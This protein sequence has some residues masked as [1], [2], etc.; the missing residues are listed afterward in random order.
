MVSSVLIVDD[1]PAFLALAARVLIGLGIEVV[2]RA[3]DAATAVR[4]AEDTRPEGALVDVGLPDR[5][6][7]DLAYELSALPWGPTVVLT[8]S[9]ADAAGAIGSRP[10]APSI[11]FVPKDQLTNGALRRHLGRD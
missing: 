10:G 4:L 11:P 3:P 7:I 6:G 2:G 5:D 9:D 1:D 8:S